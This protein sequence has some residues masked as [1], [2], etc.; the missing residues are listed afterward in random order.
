MFLLN[1]FYFICKTPL[2]ICITLIADFLCLYLQK[3]IFMYQYEKV[4]KINF[5]K[6]ATI[7]KISI[8]I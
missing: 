4:D 3:Q 1:I 8:L 7:I 5:W 2:N 6:H